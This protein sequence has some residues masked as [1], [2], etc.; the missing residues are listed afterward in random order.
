MQNP[1]PFAKKQSKHM[2]FPLFHTLLENDMT[3]LV[4]YDGYVGKNE[5]L[6]EAYNELRDYVGNDIDVNYCQFYEAT[7]IKVV[8]EI[9]PVIT[10]TIKKVK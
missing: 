6:T 3:Y 2:G 10:S 8:M 4:T 7:E 1:V 9:K 5:N